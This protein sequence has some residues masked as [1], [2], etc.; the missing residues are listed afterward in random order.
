MNR[1]I[2]A[3]LAL[4]LYSL[5]GYSQQS[6]FQITYPL[7]PDEG[8]AVSALY[9][10]DTSFWVNGIKFHQIN[11]TGAFLLRLSNSGQ[12]IS[13]KQYDKPDYS[14][15][16][17][18][19]GSLLK[20]DSNYYLGGLYQCQDPN[21][22]NIG[23]SYPFVA[24]LDL[25]GDTVWIKDYEFDT[26][27]VYLGTSFIKTHD[28]GLLLAGSASSRYINP[29][30]FDMFILKID[31]A[32]NLLWEKRYGSKTADERGSSVSELPNGN[33]LLSGVRFNSSHTQA[34]SWVLTL[35]DTGKV[36]NASLFTRPALQWGGGFTKPA[37]TGG[38]FLLGVTDTVVS[39]GDNP[40]NSYIGR[41]D[42]NGVT[43]W[44]TM[45]HSPWFTQTWDFYELDN[46]D[47]VFCGDKMDS[48]STYQFGYIAKMDSMGHI[49]WW[50]TYHQYT[51]NDNYLTCVRPAPDGGFV[52]CGSAF[53]LPNG[54]SQ[55]AWIIKTDSMGCV[56]ANCTVGV[57]DIPKAP[58]GIIVYPNP[59][60]DRVTFEFSHTGKAKIELIDGIGKTVITRVADAAKM[61]IDI[62]GLH[63][64]IYL[65]RISAEGTSQ[66]GKLIKR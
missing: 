46:G 35:D 61:S 58:E 44:L 4:L 34:S 6:K 54:T 32:G 21:N 27:R 14:Y 43:K 7:N 17:F 48:A 23:Y 52:A 45:F 26:T 24:R 60:T 41:M 53:S 57:E 63:A 19:A 5:T 59:A 42:N 33:I 13:T 66:R 1:K 18:L 30:A 36:V 11:G 56:I 2:F 65:Y 39:P 20:N 9:D 38:Y 50:N 31:T 29:G 64:G 40:N 22:V 49:L 16:G 10:T 3:L 15:G 12:V 25:N 28:G 51:G 37:R 47:I 62:S 55:D 8:W